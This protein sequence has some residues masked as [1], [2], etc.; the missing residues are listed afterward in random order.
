MRVKGGVV[1][2]RRHKRM[3][4]RAKGFRGRRSSCFKLAKRA[5][6][7]AGQHAYEGRKMKKRNFRS[8]WIMRINAAS[9]LSGLSYS[10]FMNGLKGA[11]IELNRKVLADLAAN[12][13]VAFASVAEKARA[14]LAA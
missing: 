4:E 9:R 12:D 10:R 6:E 7:K 14:A 3:L 1:T 2:R 11:G 5:V 13:P 8:L